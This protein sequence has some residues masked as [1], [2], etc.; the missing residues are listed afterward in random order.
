MISWQVSHFLN[1]KWSFE[2]LQIKYR[3]MMLLA[4]YFIQYQLP[5]GQLHGLPLL[6]TGSLNGEF[7]RGSIK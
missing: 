4:F 7:T 5:K 1:A 2:L 6:Y 3:W